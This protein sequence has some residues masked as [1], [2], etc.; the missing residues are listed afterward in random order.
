MADEKKDTTIVETP[1]APEPPKEETVK[2]QAAEAS[3]ALEKPKQ[4]QSKG[5]GVGL[6]NR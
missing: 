3:E 6:H 4:V 1:K 5:R 2:A